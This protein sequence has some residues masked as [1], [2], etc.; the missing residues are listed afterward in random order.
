MTKKITSWLGSS[1]NVHLTYLFAFM[2][3]ISYFTIG[4]EQIPFI[5]PY[6]I[7]ASISARKKRGSLFLDFSI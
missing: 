6:F 7:A 2:K 4:I 1:Q 5:L 3:R